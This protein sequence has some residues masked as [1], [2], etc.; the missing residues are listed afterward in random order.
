MYNKNLIPVQSNLNRKAFEPVDYDLKAPHSWAVPQCFAVYLRVLPDHRHSISFNPESAP[1]IKFHQIWSRPAWKANDYNLLSWLNS[2]DL[3][4]T[5]G[6][7]KKH[8]WMSNYS[9][10]FHWEGWR[11][12]STLLHLD[13]HVEQVVI[14]FTPTKC[15][16]ILIVGG[17]KQCK[18]K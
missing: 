16:R 8:Q 4:A 15:S 10:F 3:S 6:S 17:V 9:L 13:S 7:F 11:V 1:T 5:N 2:T 12:Q 18:C 14:A